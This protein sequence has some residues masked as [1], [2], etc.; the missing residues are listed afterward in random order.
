MLDCFLLLHLWFEY[1]FFNLFGFFLLQNL[2][3]HFSSIWQIHIYLQRNTFVYGERSYLICKNAD[4]GML[5]IYGCDDVSFDWFSCHIIIY[6]LNKDRRVERHPCVFGYDKCKCPTCA[7]SVAKALL[8]SICHTI[9]NIPD[10]FVTCKYGFVSNLIYS[11]TRSS[12]TQLRPLYGIVIPER[13]PPQSI[14]TENPH[15]ANIHTS[16]NLL[17]SEASPYIHRNITEIPL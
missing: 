7:P 6:S 17:R 14:S 9:P 11:N 3:I 8:R 1:F 5:S 4:A 13:P 16:L 12:N 2:H 15:Y 10:T